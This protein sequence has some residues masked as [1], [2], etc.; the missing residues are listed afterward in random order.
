MP[1]FVTQDP[2]GVLDEMEKNGSY[3]TGNHI[4][5][6]AGTHGSDY[7]D[8]DAHLRQPGVARRVAKLLA[9][10][11]QK[12]SVIIA[13]ETRSEVKLVQMV[14]EIAGCEVFSTV[15]SKDAAKTH[16][17]DPNHI[18][19]LQWNHP[20]ILID[21]VFNNGETLKQIMAA[22]ATHGLSLTEFRVMANRNP[23]LAQRLQLPFS[24]L[25]SVEIEQWKETD[26][27]AWLKERPITTQLWN[28]RDWIAKGDET[29]VTIPASRLMARKEK[30]DLG[31]HF[32]DGKEVVQ[33]KIDEF[34]L[35]KRK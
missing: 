24:A 11:I 14:W 29:D 19:L 33:M 12:G 35:H 7:L 28:G 30:E 31:F 20:R 8:K 3:V 23:A 22:L 21:D 1:K 15:K 13:P 32:D 10:G 17:I 26:V 34:F 25:A 5:Y 18:P 27:P 2:H 9:I 16:T 6:K 4:V